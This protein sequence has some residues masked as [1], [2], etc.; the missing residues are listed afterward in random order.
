MFQ[1]SYGNSLLSF[2]LSNKRIINFLSLLIVIIFSFLFSCYVIFA[3]DVLIGIFAMH[4]VFSLFFCLDRLF[5]NLAKFFC[6]NF[7][8][9]HPFGFSIQQAYFF[10]SFFFQMLYPWSLSM[11]IGQRISLPSKSVFLVAPLDMIFLILKGPDQLGFVF[12]LRSKF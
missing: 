11:L 6:L 9:S 1:I 5:F 3:H 10:F 7:C 2:N 12:P 4:M 8:L